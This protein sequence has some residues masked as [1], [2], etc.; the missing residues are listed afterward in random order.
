MNISYLEHELLSLVQLRQVH[1]V[2]SV[3]TKPAA[4]EHMLISWSMVI[5]FLTRDTR[6]V[7]S[8]LFRVA[9]ALTRQLR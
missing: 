1:T 8:T 5:I 4:F 9:M 7:K 3:I 2:A 6:I